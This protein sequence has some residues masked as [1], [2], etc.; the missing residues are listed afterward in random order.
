MF[1]PEGVYAAMLT[2]FGANG[3]INVPAI[4]DMVD[5]FVSKGI[6]GVF[7][8]S[9]VGEHIQLSE[10]EKRLFVEA[11]IEQ[12][13]GRIKVVP[14]I[15]SP[16]TEQSVKFAEFC[17]DAGADAVVLSA[18]YYFSYPQEVV[19]DAMS[20]I[21]SKSKIPVILYNIPL[22]A[23]RIGFDTFKKLLQIDSIVA[24]KD[25]SGSISDLLAFLDIAKQRE[26][27]RILVGW[28]EMLLSAMAVGASGCMVASGGILPEIMEG[29]FTLARDGNFNKAARLQAVL[30]K[31]TSA[32]K[33]VFFPY[34]YRLAMEARGF[35][36][37][38]FK[39]EIDEERY[40]QSKK[41]IQAAV[42]EALKSWV[43]M[44]GTL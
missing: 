11:A 8:V 43:D 41:A 25:S 21:A 44:A 22:F 30:A 36:M 37:G 29:I 13:G 9:N 32:M 7:P 38:K 31:A 23:N 20:S 3:R 34:G 16:G 42:D 6:Q 15:S 10:D 33:T 27:F 26:G 2:P 19:C 28:E 40:V 24:M 12:A 14:G 1:S 18:P 39:I 5:F 17:A 4:R 35:P